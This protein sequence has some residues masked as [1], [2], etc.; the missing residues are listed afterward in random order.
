MIELF[1]MFSKTIPGTFLEIFQMFSEVILETL[2]G[3]EHFKCSK[4]IT[5]TFFGIFTNG[6]TEHFQMFSEFWSRC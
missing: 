3:T 1:Q 4:V 6:V 5:G 2:F